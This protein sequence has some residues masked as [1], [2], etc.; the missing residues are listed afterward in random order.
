MTIMK[1]AIMSV[2]N[3]NSFA[4]LFDYKCII[5]IFSLIYTYEINFELKCIVTHLDSQL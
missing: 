4:Y 1:T 5:N 3:Q 2:I